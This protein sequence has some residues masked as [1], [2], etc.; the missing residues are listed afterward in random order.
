MLS[1]FVCINHTMIKQITQLLHGCLFLLSMIIQAA[2]SSFIQFLNLSVVQ[3]LEYQI[4]K[5][6]FD[7]VS[8]TIMI[9]LF[10]WKFSIKLVKIFVIFEVGLGWYFTLIQ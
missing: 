10:L 2:Q 4:I 5:Q 3:V 9:I 8:E 6:T 1:S 7:Q